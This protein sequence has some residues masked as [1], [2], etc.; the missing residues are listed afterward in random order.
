M[1][2]GIASA[3]SISSIVPGTIDLFLFPWILLVATTASIIASL[4]TAP[5][6]DEILKSFY[7]SVRPWGLWGPVRKMVL[8]EEPDFQRNRDFGRNVAS[9]AVGIV[10]QMTWVLG[11]VY[12]VIQQWNKAM[13]VGVVLVVTSIIL[14]RIW[15]DHLGN[16]EC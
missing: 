9:I 4:V 10:W 12:I 3:M 11:P 14:K 16:A 7:T 8:E 1:I 5:E 2:G 15:Y 13:W 6:S